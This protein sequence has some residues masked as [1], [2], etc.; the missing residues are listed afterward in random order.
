MPMHYRRAAQAWYNSSR[1]KQRRASQLAESPLCEYCLARENRVTPATIAD[2]KIPHRG[3]AGLFWD[4]ELQSLCKRH[5][6][7]DKQQEERGRPVIY[8]GLDGW[9]IEG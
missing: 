8:Y 1:W 5:H 9:P 6:D 7:S 2:H 3:D 4:G